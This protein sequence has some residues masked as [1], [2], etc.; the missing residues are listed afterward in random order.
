MSTIMKLIQTHGMRIV[1][2]HISNK[3]LELKILKDY[4]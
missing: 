1:L 4:L 3:S 2:I